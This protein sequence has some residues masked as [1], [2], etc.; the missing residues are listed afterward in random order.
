MKWKETKDEENYEITK[1]SVQ[2]NSLKER[3][4]NFNYYYLLSKAW[5]NRGHVLSE[6]MF[7]RILIKEIV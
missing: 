2:G 3:D 4:L 1:E 5:A 7:E 6:T